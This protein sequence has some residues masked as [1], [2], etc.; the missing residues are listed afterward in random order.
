[1]RRVEDV[2]LELEAERH[3]RRELLVMLGHELRNPLAGILGA[4][5][6][7]AARG[8]QSR[9]LD[10]LKRHARRLQTVFDELVESP[11]TEPPPRRSAVGTARQGVLVIDDG[12]DAVVVEDR[13]RV[14]VFDEDVEAALG[15]EV[16]LT[17]AGFDVALAFDGASAVRVALACLPDA[18]VLDLQAPNGCEIAQRLRLDS[19]LATTRMIALIGSDDR[20]RSR[21]TGFEHLSKPVEVDELVAIIDQR[22]DADSG[23]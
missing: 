3:R 23:L 18:I 11:R 10:A 14:L 20:E 6:M 2:E 12:S 19:R 8:P 21:A 13:R 7:L 17:K 22:R 9:E 1:M 4:V 5:A 16:L 15:L